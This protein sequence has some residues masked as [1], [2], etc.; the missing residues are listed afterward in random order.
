MLKARYGRSKSDRQPLS[1]RL[2]S[3]GAAKRA[4]GSLMEDR[5]EPDGQLISQTITV[6][7]T[8]ASIGA[9]LLFL[10]LVYIAWAQG[11]LFSL[12]EK[13]YGAM[14]GL[15]AA[16]GLALIIVAL[17]RQREGPIELE[18]PGFKV[19]GATGPVLL[20]VICFLAIA[21]A[22]KEMWSLGVN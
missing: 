21:W 1:E 7:A 18:A 12:I 11:H 14:V 2:L 19:K 17:F 20:W 9:A 15:P 16:A 22:M 3:T 4:G 10:A 8:I 13:H 6:L 5:S